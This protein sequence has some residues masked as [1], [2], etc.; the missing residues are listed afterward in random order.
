ME[1]RPRQRGR[2]A[3]ELTPLIDVV[4]QLL[5][6]FL[7]TASF[8][9]PSLRLDLPSGEASDEPDAKPILVEIDASGQATSENI[10]FDPGRRVR[11]L[12][13]RHAE[14]LLADRSDDFS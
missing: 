14:L 6:F 3:L 11:V 2:T 13:G 9:Q 12:K 8:V 10:P 1:I 7:L 4:F 5:V